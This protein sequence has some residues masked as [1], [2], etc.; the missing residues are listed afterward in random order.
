R[1]P[2]HS[3]SIPLLHLRLDSRPQSGAPATAIY[4]LSTTC[5]LV[6]TGAGSAY[7]HEVLRMWRRG[8]SCCFNV[9]PLYVY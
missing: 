4:D 1:R 6:A 2:T 9:N 7:Q 3:N 8:S 5:F